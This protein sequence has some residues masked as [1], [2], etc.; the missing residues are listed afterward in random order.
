[1]DLHVTN[2]EA[3][4]AQARR[5][6]Q[7]IERFRKELRRLVAASLPLIDIGK[8]D[9]TS[10]CGPIHARCSVACQDRIGLQGKPL[11]RFEVPGE[12][13]AVGGDVIQE[14]LRQQGAVDNFPERF[15][16]FVIL[17]S[18]VG[19]GAEYKPYMRPRTRAGG[20]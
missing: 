18:E 16:G 7:D 5:G 10:G 1:M 20:R 14:P 3:E 12:Q 17:A 13:C 9:S 6:A 2:A 8:L 4:S 19:D 15:R 11:C